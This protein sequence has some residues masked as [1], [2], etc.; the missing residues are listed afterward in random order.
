M[1]NI[2]LHHHF[3]W[4]SERTSHFNALHC[5]VLSCAVI[6]KAVHVQFYY[7]LNFDG[8]FVSITGSFLFRNEI[9][10][11]VVIWSWGSDVFFVG[12]SG[13]GDGGGSGGG[14]SDG[15]DGDGK[16]AKLQQTGTS[17]ERHNCEWIW[18]AMEQQAVKEYN[19]MA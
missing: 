9:D 11:A 16:T 1:W 4:A 15:G 8:G 10:I 13:D 12:I 6:Q 14:G 19:G 18:T 2:A 3:C 5:T 17:T 7:K